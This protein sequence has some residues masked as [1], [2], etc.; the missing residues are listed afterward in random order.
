MPSYWRL[1]FVESA[2]ERNR[3]IENLELLRDQLKS[4]M[5]QK[6]ADETLILGTWNIRNFDDNRFG[7]GPRLKDGSVGALPSVSLVQRDIFFRRLSLS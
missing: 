6:T 7:H 1:K 5:P 2:K 3:I 4:R